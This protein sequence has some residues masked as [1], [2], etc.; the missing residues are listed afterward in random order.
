MSVDDDINRKLKDHISYMKLLNTW[1]ILHLVL[2]IWIK[3]SSCSIIT[4]YIA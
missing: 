4:L 1:K 3:N 2:Q